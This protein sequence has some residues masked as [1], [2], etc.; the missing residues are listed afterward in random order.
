MTI[1]ILTVGGTIDKDYFDALSEY[2]IVHSPMEDLFSAINVTF[3][4]HLTSLMKKDSLEMTDEDRKII[5][6]HIKGL[7]EKQILITH[8]TDTMSKTA[9]FLMP[10]KD[11]TIVLTGAMKPARFKD[12]DAI[13]NIGF[14][15]GAL[16][17]LPSG[18]YIAMSGKIFPAGTVKKNREKGRFE[19]K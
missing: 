2:K 4:H 8:G 1:A 19:E 3:D 10:I 15:L 7:Q 18:V 9:E 12:T 11:K 16:H 5:Y 17:A 13:F 14:A 6:N